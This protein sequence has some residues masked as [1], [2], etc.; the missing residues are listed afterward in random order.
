M[1]TLSTT[2]PEATPIHPLITKERESS[3]GYYVVARHYEE[4][5]HVEVCGIK[6]MSGDQLKRGGGGKRKNKDRADMDELTLQ[7]SRSRSKTAARRKSLALC[8]DRILTL[9]FR[10]NLTDVNKAW[11]VFKMFSRYMRESFGET[12]RYVAV[13]EYQKRGA[14]HF[15]LAIN[16]RYP[17]KKVR[18]LWLKAAGKYKGNIDITD[19]K[20]FGKNSWNPRRCAAYIAKYITKTD[21]TDFN[22]RRYSSGGNIPLP[23]PKKGWLTY[24]APIAL[25][26]SQVIQK[27][28]QNPIA[29]MWQ[30]DDNAG[31]VFYST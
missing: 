15:H 29:C 19:P 23:E 9:T 16:G 5:E 27:F 20:R 7:K 1:K 11:A 8:T 18:K 25:T 17:V 6:L 31:I 26:F 3:N 4:A 21:V 13:P 22:K 10:E 14:V 30:S 12:Y 24:G 2:E 28:T